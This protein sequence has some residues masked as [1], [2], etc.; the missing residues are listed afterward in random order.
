M[1]GTIES[2]V[3]PASN[4]YEIRNCLTRY[5]EQQPWEK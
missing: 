4:T 5:K 3:A 2:V 1:T